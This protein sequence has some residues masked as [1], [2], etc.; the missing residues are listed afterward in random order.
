MLPGALSSDHT[1]PLCVCLFG[2]ILH[3]LPHKFKQGA[4]TETNGCL[5]FLISP[6]ELTF[7]HLFSL[8]ITHRLTHTYTHTHTPQPKT[9]LFP[10]LRNVPPSSWF[11]TGQPLGGQII[12]CLPIGANDSQPIT[13]F[14]RLLNI[15]DSVF[16]SPLFLWLR[17]CRTEQQGIGKPFDIFSH[18]LVT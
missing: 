8:A 13:D 18:I 12:I 9:F 10:V 5:P 16:F 14:V 6:P 4:D 17:G 7:Q 2:E 1:R 15:V 3:F 11:L